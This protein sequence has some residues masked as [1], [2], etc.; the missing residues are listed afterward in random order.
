MKTRFAERLEFFSVLV[1]ILGFAGLS[2][3][4]VIRWL[5]DVSLEN[6]IGSLTGSIALWVFSGLFVLGFLILHPLAVL[7]KARRVLSS[8]ET[9]SMKK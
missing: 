4:A 5:F 6:F 9:K 8:G 2:A 1:W 7:L 3:I